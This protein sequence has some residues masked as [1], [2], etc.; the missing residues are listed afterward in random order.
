ML[1]LADFRSRALPHSLPLY[2][3][4][5]P[6]VESIEIFMERTVR[7]FDDVCTTVAKSATPS[8]PINTTLINN[9]VSMGTAPVANVLVAAH[10]G[11]I[12]MHLM[13]FESQRYYI[14]GS[15][16]RATPNTALSTFMV[17]VDEDG[18][19]LDVA[20]FHLHDNSHIVQ[21]RN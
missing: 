14:P 5:P 1:P 4:S 21:Q 17:T 16:T 9:D 2:L 13:Y 7:F 10:G 12:R 3:R 18:K 20:C 19:C 8:V 11:V 15:T 6:T